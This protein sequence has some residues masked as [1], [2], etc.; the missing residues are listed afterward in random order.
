MEVN[1]FLSFPLSFDDDDGDDD[2][3]F[4]TTFVHGVG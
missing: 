3:C 4:T 2:W 1:V